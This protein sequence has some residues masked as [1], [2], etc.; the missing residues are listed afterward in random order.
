MIN[1]RKNTTRLLQLSR[2]GRRLKQASEML[3]SKA[4]SVYAC[5]LQLRFEG[6]IKLRNTNRDWPD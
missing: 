4:L 1:F 2:D 5:L 6:V 3:F